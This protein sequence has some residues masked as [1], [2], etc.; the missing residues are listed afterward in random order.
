MARA[1]WL[2]GGE[3]SRCRLDRG[4]V[5]SRQEKLPEPLHGPPL[6]QRGGTVP[7]RRA[8]GQAPIHAARTLEFTDNPGREH[9]WAAL[10]PAVHRRIAE[11][12]GSTIEWWAYC[13]PVQ[14]TRPYAVVFGTDG[15]G[16]TTP[17]VNDAGRPAHR[18][19]VRRFTSGSVRHAM[20]NQ[21]PTNRP[22]SA[23]P[24]APTGAAAALGL[25]DELCGFL[26]NLPAEAQARMQSPF[27]AG[28]Q[29]EDSNYFYTRTT[30][31]R[32]DVWCYLA[33]RRIVTFVSGHR[34]A[35][36]GA[37]PHA[38]SWQLI[39]RMAEVAPR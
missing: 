6:V 19:N 16:V 30:D 31:R 2:P 17:L 39:C 20:V 18:I 5:V 8:D 7:A 21:R 28:D 37:A 26:G 22:P 29:V 1:A 38:A 3:R 13:D 12:V 23:G 33:G 25:G 35:P 4:G 14:A 11:K 9:W 32:L 15:L 10:G 27:L 36:E 24:P 34:D